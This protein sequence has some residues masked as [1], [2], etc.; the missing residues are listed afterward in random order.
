MHDYQK[1]LFLIKK[2]YFIEAL[3][4]NAQAWIRFSNCSTNQNIYNRKEKE[5]TMQDKITALPSQIRVRVGVLVIETI[6]AL[7]LQSRFCCVKIEGM[8]TPSIIVYL[9]TYKHLYCIF[10]FDLL[11][12]ELPKLKNSFKTS[13]YYIGDIP[14]FGSTGRCI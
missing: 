12:L 6:W 5:R 4:D 11:F 14:L 8:V 10:L 9:I 7:C 13:P 1:Q 2:L 3:R